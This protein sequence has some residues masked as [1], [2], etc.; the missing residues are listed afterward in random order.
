VPFLRTANCMVNGHSSAKID[1]GARAY[2]RAGHCGK[3]SNERE[4]ESFRGHLACR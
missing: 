4:P 2:L 1:G 3:Y